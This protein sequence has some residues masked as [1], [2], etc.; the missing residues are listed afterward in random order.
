MKQILSVDDCAAIFSNLELLRGLNREILSTLD[1]R[2]NINSPETWILGD[3]FEKMASF[4]KMYTQYC[5][6]QDQALMTVERCRKKSKAFD[7]FLRDVEYSDAV[8]GLSLGAYLIK[9]V[10]RIC[11]Y[12]LLL[13]S[14]LDCTEGDH[15]DKAN[16]GNAMKK[17]AEV[18]FWIE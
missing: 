5:S 7:Q 18:S 10:Q 8:H 4:M 6:N 3:I 11:K 2:I 17:M 16:L 12:P 9:P 14:L 15:P 1:Q 13:K